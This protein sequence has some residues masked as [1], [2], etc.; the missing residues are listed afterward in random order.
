MGR[1][2]VG[3]FGLLVGGAAGMFARGVPPWQRVAAESPMTPAAPSAPAAP[4]APAAPA[5]SAASRRDVEL[6]EELSTKVEGKPWWV[7]SEPLVVAAYEN[8]YAMNREMRIA[9]EAGWEIDTNE[10][11]R[12]S[13]EKRLH[14][15]EEAYDKRPL[16]PLTGGR[17]G[18]GTTITWRRITPP[19]S[20]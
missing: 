11:Q 3:L 15:N 19:E 12:Q 8:I 14:G 6:A 5:R 18:T 1:L 13:V 4:P 2:L 10:F 16:T 20:K 7:S 9:F 17:P